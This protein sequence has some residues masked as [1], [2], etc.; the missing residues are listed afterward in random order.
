MTQDVLARAQASNLGLARFRIGEYLLREPDY[1]QMLRWAGSL[2]LTPEAL[3]A[4]LAAIRLEP[5]LGGYE[6]LGL[7]IEDG[8]II[9]LAWDFERLAL[10]PATWESG[11]LVRTIG[12]CGNWPDAY[13]PLRP[14]LPR[15]QTLIC[16]EIGLE[17]IDL[18]KLPGLTGLYCWDNSLTELDLSP[19][20]RLTMLRC[21]RNQLTELDLS[22][23]PGL[24][25]LHC[26]ENVRVLNAPA[27]LSIRRQ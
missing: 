21:W 3:L 22:P 25:E 24:T 11:L 1:R 6:P 15:L 8:A 13:T 14:V 19:V 26:D 20:P 16:P 10:I 18:S 5:L 7:A 17:S 4:E 9:S 2:E 12:F 23:V 27:N